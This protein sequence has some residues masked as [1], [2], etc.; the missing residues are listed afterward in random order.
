MLLLRTAV[1]MCVCLGAFIAPVIGQDTSTTVVDSPAEAATVETAHQHEE[2]EVAAPVETPRKPPT[3]LDFL[4]TPKYLTWIGFTII[5]LVLLLGRWINTWVRL[6]GLVAVFVVFGLDYFFPLHP[7]PMCGITKL[8]MFKFTQGVFFPA[9]LVI[10]LAMMVP[11]LI[12][13]KLF[14]GWVCPLGALQELV[15]KIPSKFR[16]K[17]FNF[18]AFNS[19]RVALLVMF[20]LTFFLVKEQIGMLAGQVGSD[21][22]Q[23]I[24]R[25]FAAYSVYE[26]INFFELLHWDFAAVDTVWVVMFLV[27]LVSSYVL[28]RPFCYLICPIGALTWLLELIAPGRVRVDHELCNDCGVCV[29]KSPCPTIAKL[30]DK[31][32]KVAPDCTSCG[33][34]L[35]TCPTDAIKFGFSK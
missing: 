35:S 3:T 29:I 1:L 32:T 6:I 22:S 31:N 23:G 27:L 10:F 16:W 8:F 24:W 28:Y 9:F 20:F 33:E 4:L 15:N 17:Q 14:C 30:I 34:C 25:A 11:S 13:R 7:S 19:I 5:G 26:P 2:A 12:G 18:K 21:P